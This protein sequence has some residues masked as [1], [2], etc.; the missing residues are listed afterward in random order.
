MYM[1]RGLLL[2]SVGDRNRI[3]I[4]VDRSCGSCDSAERARYSGRQRYSLVQ[5]IISFLCDDRL[6]ESERLR[7]SF[8][9]NEATN[10]A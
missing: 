1:Q 8:R 2:L 9:S 10:P 5:N 4:G 6:R 7:L 3:P